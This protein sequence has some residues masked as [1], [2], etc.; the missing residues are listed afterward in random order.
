MALRE[1]K[2]PANIPTIVEN[3][4]ANKANHTGI[5]DKSP[6]VPIKSAATPNLLMAKA[7]I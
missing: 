1:G 4:K 2:K 6:V 5:C 3:T 7:A